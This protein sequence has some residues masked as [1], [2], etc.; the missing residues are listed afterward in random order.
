MARCNVFANASS[1]PLASPRRPGQIWRMT[2][3]SRLVIIGLGYSGTAVAREA[4]AL[5]WSVTGTARE[6]ARAAPPAGVAVV[7]FADAGWRIV[8][9]HV[10]MMPQG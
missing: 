10:S 8:A 2:E 1:E 5:G 3:A 7:R 4:R 6:L 9:A